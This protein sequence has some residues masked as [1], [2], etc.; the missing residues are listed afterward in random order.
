MENQK[1]VTFGTCEISHMSPQILTVDPQ[2]L[3]LTISYTELFKFYFSILA[4]INKLHKYNFNTK[5]GK[6]AGAVLM[7]QLEKG[8]IGI[9]EKGM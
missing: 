3:N 2:M 4:C 7:I 9:K 5:V 1:K 8:R 6:N